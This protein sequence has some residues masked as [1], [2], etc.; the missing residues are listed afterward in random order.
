MKRSSGAWYAMLAPRLSRDRQG[1][2]TVS[3]RRQE[4]PGPPRRDRSHPRLHRAG[5]PA[6]HG[7][8]QRN[9]TPAELRQA[10]DDIPEVIDA[11][12]VS[13]GADAM[14]YLPARDIQHLAQAIQRVRSTA[15][16]ART[17]SAISA[18]HP[19]TAVNYSERRDT[20]KSK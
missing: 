8:A 5:R 11:C 16:V 14:I 1:R 15:P 4:S 19:A 2:R 18:A 6:V 12:I 20:G 3:V 10:L 17:E 13:G 7:L 9:P